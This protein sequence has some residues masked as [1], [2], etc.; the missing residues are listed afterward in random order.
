MKPKR[1]KK[2]ATVE[3]TW[4]ITAVDPIELGK[5]KDWWRDIHQAT[6]ADPGIYNSC[7]E[8]PGNVYEV[9]I[10]QQRPF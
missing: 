9:Q 7:T 1:E 5:V 2:M 10:T 6:E 8:L 3:F 4:R